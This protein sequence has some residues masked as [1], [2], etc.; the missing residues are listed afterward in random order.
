ML[1]NEILKADGGDGLP[2]FDSLME[3]PAHTCTCMHVYM[4]ARTLAHSHSHFYAHR[5]A[6]RYASAQACT[7]TSTH[8]MHARIYAF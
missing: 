4:H 8:G 2:N 6:G 7:H 3:T 5:H 1:L